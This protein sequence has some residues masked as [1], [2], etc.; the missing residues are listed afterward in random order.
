M[1]WLIDAFIN[2]LAAIAT[3]GVSLVFIVI[4]TYF[5]GLF[6]GTAWEIVNEYRTGR[7]QNGDAMIGW[8]IAGGAWALFVCFNAPSIGAMILPCLGFIALALVA[9]IIAYVLFPSQ[10]RPASEFD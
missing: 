1:Y 10:S 2:L 4:T 9:N 3:I 5:V 8:G 6:A 7:Y